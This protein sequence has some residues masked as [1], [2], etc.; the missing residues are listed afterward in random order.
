MGSD[1]K[2]GTKVVPG[3]DANEAQLLRFRSV[4]AR[5]QEA[6]NTVFDRSHLRCLFNTQMEG[7]SRQLDTGTWASGRSQG[8]KPM[9]SLGTLDRK[10]EGPGRVGRHGGG[11]Q[12]PRE[13]GLPGKGPE[14][15]DGMLGR[16]PTGVGGG[17]QK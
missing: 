9:W 2:R 1:K 14:R 13:E 3:F 16:G 4:G 5:W 11:C 15:S 7:P 6:K 10:S 8:W 17:T 12:E